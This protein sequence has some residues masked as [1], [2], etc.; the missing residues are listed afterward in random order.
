MLHFSYVSLIKKKM[1]EN[2]MSLSF[3]IKSNFV[4][5]TMTHIEVCDK[6]CKSTRGLNTFAR[7]CS[8]M[9]NLKKKGSAKSVY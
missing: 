1:F 2:H 4:L 6:L 3:K 9:Q 8:F 7:H 5:E